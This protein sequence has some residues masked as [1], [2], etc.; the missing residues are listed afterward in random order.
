MFNVFIRTVV[1]YVVALFV[2]RV[3]GKSELSKLDPF[4]LVALFMI[5]ELAA[6]PIATPNVAVITGVAAMIG[7]LLVQV[8]VSI[9]SIK[10]PLFNNI[11]K[12][13]ASVI[14]EKGKIIEKEMKKHRMTVDDL[15]QQLRIKNYPSIADIDYAILEANGDM[16]V[17]PKP[18]KNAA[19]RKDLG[20]PTG[21]EGLPMVLIADG[22]LQK[23]NLI[24]ANLSEDMLMNRLRFEGINE[25]KE[26]FLCFVDEVGII[27]IHRKT[28]AKPNMSDNENKNPGSDIQ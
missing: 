22:L 9:L 27:H 24:R 10:S 13:K 18:D 23:D 15:S 7:L 11:V 28:S 4:Q 1:L 6:L 2:I 12:G 19:T 3:M 8:T 5:A 26:I 16:S 21:T 17:I 20:V 14:I 25:Y